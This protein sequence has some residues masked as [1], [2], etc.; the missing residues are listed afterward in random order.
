MTFELKEQ[1]NILA[2]INPALGKDVKKE[3]LSVE[4]YNAKVEELVAKLATSQFTSWKDQDGRWVLG[5]K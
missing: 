4:A 3:D 1:T 2:F 5:F